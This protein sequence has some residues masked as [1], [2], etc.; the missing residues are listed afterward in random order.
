MLKHYRYRNATFMTGNV[1]S[2]WQWSSYV[3][4][5]KASGV[6]I[7]DGKEQAFDLSA[8]PKYLTPIWKTKAAK[9]ADEH[10]GV[11][12]Y[13]IRHFT[14]GNEPIMVGVIITTKQHNVLYVSNYKP[15]YYEIMSEACRKVTK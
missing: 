1:T 4:P 7:E 12:I 15:M 14:K 9:L 13:A 10:N 11:I 2:N 3:R 8:F 6:H 5:V